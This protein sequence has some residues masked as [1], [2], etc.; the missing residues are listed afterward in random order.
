M[1]GP[2]KRSAKKRN[3]G[4]A[5]FRRGAQKA[6]KTQKAKKGE[7]AD[8]AAASSEDRDGPPT[9][10]KAGFYTKFVHHFEQIQ[11]GAWSITSC[12][13][14]CEAYGSYSLEDIP[15]GA[16]P[17]PGRKHRG[18]HSYTVDARV[19][20]P[21]GN[22][23]DITVDVLLRAKA[24]YIKKA[25]PVGRLGQISWKKFGGPHPAWCIALDQAACGNAG[26]S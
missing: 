20:D 26:K 4:K 5:S 8:R 22:L 10:A 18:T 25:T 2:P 1:N 9:P 7:G 21:K 3:K 14:A 24:Y 16:R 19:Q 12:F 15:I 17:Q 13:Q 11:K 6:N 23:C